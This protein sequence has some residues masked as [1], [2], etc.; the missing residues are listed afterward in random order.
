MFDAENK[1]VTEKTSAEDN[2]TFE[3]T[4]NGNYKAEVK[5]TTDGIQKEATKTIKVDNWEMFSDI[6]TTTKEYTDSEGNTAWIPQG[7][8]VGVS[9]GINKISK[10]L[11]I[12]DKIDEG[13]NST[14]NEFVWI[15]VGSYKFGTEIKTNNL[16]RR[17]WGTTANEVVMPTEV[18][19]D[20][21]V[22]G[23]NG[24][25][26]QGESQNVTTFLSKAKEKRGFY[27][28][29]YEQGTGNV[30]K[31]NVETY[32]NVTRDQAKTQAENLYSGN[33][34]VGSELISSYAWDTALN[35][36]CQTHK[37]G[38]KIAT[39]VNSEYGNLG[40]GTKIQRTGIYKADEYNNIHDILGNVFEL[41]TGYSSYN[42]APYV[43]RGAG[44]DYSTTYF[45]CCRGATTASYFHASTGFRVQ[46]YV[47]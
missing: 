18:E 24:N 1:E 13:H 45:A 9:D 6:Y 28:G 34:Y 15:P 25:Y 11:V 42:G 2:K 5:A 16:V 14:G 32:T 40:S 21:S 12:T 4:K 38:Y 3:V 36:I 30:V 43:Y 10:G 44:A 39:V 47:K 31:K 27:I 23:F 8:A 26:Y 17:Q 20:V 29:R 41:T 35:F 33:Q 37:D 22:N 46:I 7:F 19:G